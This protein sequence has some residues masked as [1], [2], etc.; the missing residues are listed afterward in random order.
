VIELKRVVRRKVFSARGE[1]LV[2][3][4]A[5]EGVW[6]RQLRRRHSYLLPYGVALQTAVRLSV[7][8]LRREKAAKVARAR[9]ARRAR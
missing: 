8:A 7:D 9:A 6:V 4:L 3:L 2:V 1:S 5:P